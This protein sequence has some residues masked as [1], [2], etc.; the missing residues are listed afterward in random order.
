[1]GPEQNPLGTSPCCLLLKMLSQD[2][3][4]PSPNPVRA[5]QQSRQRL[6]PRGMWVP[7]HKPC[8]FFLPSVPGTEHKQRGTSCVYFY[9]SI[10]TS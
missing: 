9:F 4:I 5:A 7:A 2:A 10:S 3:S 1:M 8:E 6:A